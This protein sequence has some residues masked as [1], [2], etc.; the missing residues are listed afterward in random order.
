MP[1]FPLPASARPATA[2]SAAP[3]QRSPTR[4]ALAVQATWGGC[5][6]SPRLTSR[7]TLRSRSAAR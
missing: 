2:S 3:F 7:L 4:G 1:E 6:R 5:A